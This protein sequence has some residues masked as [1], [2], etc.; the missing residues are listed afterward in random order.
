V[1]AKEY[2]R[3]VYDVTNELL[4]TKRLTDE[5]YERA[6]SVLGLQ[7]LIELVSTIGFYMTASALVNAFDVPPRQEGKRLI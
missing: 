4:E 2:E 6:L 1:F 3:L 7:N 5:T